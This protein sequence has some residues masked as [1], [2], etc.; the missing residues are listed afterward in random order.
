MTDSL[1]RLS[2]LPFILVLIY[3]FTQG[4]LDSFGIET[5]LVLVSLIALMLI[6]VFN[7]QINEWWWKRRP[8]TLDKPLISWLSR[9]S[10]YYNTLNETQ[11]LAFQSSIA[12]FMKLKNFTLKGKRDYQ[13]EEDIKLIVAHEFARVFHLREEMMNESYHQVVIY[14]HA[15]GS[16]AI[17]ELHTL[18][19][20]RED[21]VLILSKE[22][23]V[24]G[25]LDP[26]QY[27]NVALLAAVMIFIELNPR[28]HYPDTSSLTIEGIAESFHINTEAI[29]QALGVT[30]INKLDL[31]L[32]CYFLTSSSGTNVSHDSFEGVSN[33]FPVN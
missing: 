9:F 18:E 21:E 33:I 27:V 25:F 8:L 2:A 4:G 19:L 11:Q 17:Q 5:I 14:N 20:Y 15:F 3:C 12:R 7:K 24:Q 1:S 13:V 30:Y 22:Q 28:L 26:K 10:P 16:P 32:F 6:Y 29:Y 23:L 31:L